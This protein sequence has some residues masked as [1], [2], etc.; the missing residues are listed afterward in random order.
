MLGPLGGIRG[1]GD[2]RG[3]LGWQVHWEPDHIGPQSRVPASPLVPLGEWPTWQRPSRWQK[4]AL[5]AIMN[6]WNYI[7]W[8]FS[9]LYL[10]HLITYSCMQYKEMLYGLF[11]LQTNIYAYSY[12][13]NL[14][15]YDTVVLIM[16][17]FFYHQIS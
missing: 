11:S 10:C 13:I 7:S 12:T 9:H 16:K 15:Y 3:V 1:V 17:N 14:T 6:I 4:W 5:Q 2:V 8:Q